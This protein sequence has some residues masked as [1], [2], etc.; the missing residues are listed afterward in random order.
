MWAVWTLIGS[1]PASRTRFSTK[2]G[3]WS[4][5][6]SASATLASASTT[7]CPRMRDVAA[8][9][10]LA[11]RKT[12]HHLEAR[13]EC[14]RDV[15]RLDTHRL[16]AGQPDA[17]QHKNRRVERHQE[18]VGHPGIRLH[19]V[20]PQDAGCGGQVVTPHLLRKTG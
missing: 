16:A 9:Q 7:Y 8:L 12:F 20:L 2:I 15:G 18:R 17:L 14:G 19:N 1:P 5:T 6:R 11:Q 10:N 13:H 4:G 3:E